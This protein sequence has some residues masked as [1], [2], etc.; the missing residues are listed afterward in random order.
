MA[1]L[2][3]R[4]IA[5]QQMMKAEAHA[6][7]VM[8]VSNQASVEVR[9]FTLVSQLPILCAPENSAE[10]KPWVPR[11][12]FAYQ[13]ME[14][15]TS[16][17]VYVATKLQ[18]EAKLAIDRAMKALQDIDWAR[19]EQE[20][21]DK[22][23]DLKAKQIRQELHRAFMEIT[24]KRISE[25][26]ISPADNVREI[27]SQAQAEWQKKLECFQRAR[28]EKRA[29]QEALRKQIVD[30][31]LMENMKPGQQPRKAVSNEAIDI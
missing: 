16:P 18:E 28:A 8:N 7:M 21:K 3:E 12:S 20:L 10:I 9:D 23:I 14:D 11:N 19:L 22:G 30:E 4:R 31:R 1:S 17:K 29:R 15:S 26:S 13:Y 6:R 24:W 5:E 27:Y 25:G 2:V